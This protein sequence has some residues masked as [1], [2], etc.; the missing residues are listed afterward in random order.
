M[1]HDQ[2]TNPLHQN[3]ATDGHDL[4]NSLEQSANGQDQAALQT[5]LEELEQMTTR[6]P[7]RLRS[8]DASTGIGQAWEQLSES[9]QRIDASEQADFQVDHVLTGLWNHIDHLPAKRIS[10]GGL[11]ATFSLGAVALASIAVL[12]VTSSS[13]NVAPKETQPKQPQPQTQPVTLL[14]PDKELRKKRSEAPVNDEALLSEQLVQVFEQDE[15]LL[16]NLLAQSLDQP[17][18][19]APLE[20]STDADQLHQFMLQRQ[21]EWAEEDF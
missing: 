6:H 16:I 2:P 8:S 5:L 12:F 1:N 10:I 11:L 17:N 4:V 19:V 9:L 18:R 13:L 21:R 20:Q 14:Q 7:N 3:G 15:Q